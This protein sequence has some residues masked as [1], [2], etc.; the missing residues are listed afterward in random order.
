VKNNA[1]IKFTKDEVDNIIDE[2]SINTDVERIPL[3][4]VSCKSDIE[5]YRIKGKEYRCFIIDSPEAREIACRPSVVGAEIEKLSGKLAAK[6]GPAILETGA[7]TN[8][9]IFEHILR[10]SVGYHLH[11]FLIRYFLSNDKKNTKIFQ[12]WI[13]TRYT[14]PSYKDHNEPEKT[15]VSTFEDFSA[16][17]S[18]PSKAADLV[19]QDTIA[20]GK[21]LE[22]SLGRA[23]AE[24]EKR[25]IKIKNVI[26]YGFIAEKG[27]DYVWKKIKS[28][29]AKM[30]A[31]AIS[32]LTPLC[33]N[34]YDMPLYGPDEP[35]YNE[36]GTLKNLGA[37]ISRDAFE[38]YAELFIPGLDQPGDFSA[39]LLKLYNGKSFEES[40]IPIHLKR[41]YDYLNRIEKL[42]K[43]EMPMLY[44]KTSERI[45]EEKKKLA[46]MMEMNKEREKR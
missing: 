31:F 17:D 42:L 35:L 26:F 20:S 12:T 1:R 21:T 23:F 7:I 10:A 46:Y 22:F 43:E 45:S 8:P 6:A 3:K 2:F 13:R 4:S 37:T 40:E 11:D 15:L 39:R 5:L 9:I 34:N 24:A 36:K 19:V 29:S 44:R 30:C 41:S 16:L 14:Y 33:S 28:R 25:D 27:L 32:D 38:R 18:I